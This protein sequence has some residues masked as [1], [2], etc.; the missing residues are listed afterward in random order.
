MIYIYIYI[1]SEKLTKVSQL[2]GQ[3]LSDLFSTVQWWSYVYPIINNYNLRNTAL[4]FVKMPAVNMF[5]WKLKR[6]F[7]HLL[8]LDLRVHFMTPPPPDLNVHGCSYPSLKD[9]LFADSG[10]KNTPFLRPE[11]HPL[12]KQNA[13]FSVVLYNAPYLWK[14]E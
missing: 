10:R 4:L 14:R 13:I 12:F 7:K 5:I 1:F 11:K 3:H 8:S 9:P 6:T 2:N